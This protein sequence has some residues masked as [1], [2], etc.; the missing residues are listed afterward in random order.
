MPDEARP[1]VLADQASLPSDLVSPADA[2]GEAR[3][4]ELVDADWRGQ[5]ANALGDFRFAWDWGMTEQQRAEA[6]ATVALDREMDKLI[7]GVADAAVRPPV[8][9]GEFAG[10]MIEAR[11][12]RAR[13][14]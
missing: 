7:G 4:K 13:R 1:Y 6:L 2:L 9:P 3:W 5:G 8:D 11:M 12:E 10:R 14:A